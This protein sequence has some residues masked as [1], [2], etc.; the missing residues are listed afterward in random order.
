[1]MMMIIMVLVCALDLLGNT[2]IIN[3]SQSKLALL[4][5]ASLKSYE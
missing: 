1:M 5:S 2:T 4:S 3:E